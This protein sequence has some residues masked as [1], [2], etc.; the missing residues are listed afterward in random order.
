MRAL[1]HADSVDSPTGTTFAIVPVTKSNSL[2][3][4]T[5]EVMEKSMKYP[6]LKKIIVF[7]DFVIT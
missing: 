2:T 3:Y 7:I 6:H 5:Q 1:S 4:T